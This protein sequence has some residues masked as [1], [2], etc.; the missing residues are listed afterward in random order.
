L[1]YK[2]RHARHFIA[3]AAC[4]PYE[5][6]LKSGRAATREEIERDV[7]RLFSVNFRKWVGVKSPVARIKAVS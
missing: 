5:K 1:I 4:E 7:S 3:D 6:L 2:W